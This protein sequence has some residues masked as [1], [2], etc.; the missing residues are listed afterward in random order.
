MDKYAPV[1]FVRALHAGPPLPG[2][3]RNLKG[4]YDNGG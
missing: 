3:G 2:T 4:V 1:H